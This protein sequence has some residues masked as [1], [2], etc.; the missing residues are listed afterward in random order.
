MAEYTYT[1]IFEHL[2]QGGYQVSVPALPEIVTFGRTREEAREMAKDAIRCVLES[3]R[4]MK[5]PI[6]EDV[7]PATERV[8]ITLP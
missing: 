3:A 4:K 1:V 2:P 8:A 6:P 5:E 7:E